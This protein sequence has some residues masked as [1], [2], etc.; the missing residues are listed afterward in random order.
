MD[1]TFPFTPEFNQLGVMVQPD[2]YITLAGA[3]DLHVEGQTV[4]ELTQS[5]QKAYAKIL[6]DPVVT[7]VLK[8][9]DKP[10]YIAS[11]E[12][13]HPGKYDLRGDITVTQGLAIAGGLNDKAKHS[14]VLLFRR[15]SNNWYEVKKVDVK[16]LL[17]ARNLNEDLHLQ[18]G[19]MLFVP[20]SAVG[21]IKRFIPSA[22]MGVYYNPH[23]Y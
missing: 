9:F 17:Q 6:H 12:V 22:G 11:G 10:Y 3:G 2:G 16:R 18:P 19:D 23:P 15:V 4:P 13:Q 1:L 20:T 21:N 8:D 5:L 7:V 14:Q